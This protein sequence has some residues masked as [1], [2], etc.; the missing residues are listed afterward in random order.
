MTSTMTK[1]PSLD[2]RLDSFAAPQRATK[3]RGSWP[4]G[5]HAHDF[6]YESESFGTCSQVEIKRTD[7]AISYHEMMW[8]FGFA[9][10]LLGAWTIEP[11]LVAEGG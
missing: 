4:P 9:L 7:A 8:A 5:A 10:L 2:A 6:E 3:R 11:S 1:A